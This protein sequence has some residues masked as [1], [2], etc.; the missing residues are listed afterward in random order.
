MSKSGNT[1]LAL[2]TGAAI[3][4]GA[5]ILYAPD[6]GEKTRKKLKKKATK[7]QDR[8]KKQLENASQVI[9]NKFQKSSSLIEERLEDTLSNASYKADDIIVA[10]EHKL[11][12]LREK[13]AKLQKEKTT[14][15]A[16]V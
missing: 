12:A 10:L 13:N 4:V 14:A 3:G 15:V 5:G 6:K 16:K 8:I 1:L 2:I 11:E 7:E 9:T